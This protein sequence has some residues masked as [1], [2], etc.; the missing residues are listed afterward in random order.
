MRYFALACDYDSTLAD[1]GI[2][3]EST[4]AALRRLAASGR[5]LILVTGREL[6]DLRRVFP[7][8]GVF[9]RIIAENGALLYVPSTGKSKPLA[10]PP[11]A[12]FVDA[13]RQARVDPLSVGKTIL[14][15]VKPYD[16]TVLNDSTYYYQVTALDC[17][18]LESTPSASGSVFVPAAP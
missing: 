11:P 17:T 16:A 10:D 12:N 4:V 8:H 5:K 1:Q 15:T 2:V 7:A 9:D 14:S 13:L 3:R 18:P 6:D